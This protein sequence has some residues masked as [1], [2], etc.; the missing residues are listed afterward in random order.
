MVSLHPDRVLAILIDSTGRID[1]RSL[2]L[3]DH[4]EQEL[5]S[6]DRAT[7]AA[8]VADLVTAYESVAAQLPSAARS[9]VGLCVRTLQAAAREGML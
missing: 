4:T 9:Y 3:N 2:Q 8:D 7:R 6:V 1:Q 5:A